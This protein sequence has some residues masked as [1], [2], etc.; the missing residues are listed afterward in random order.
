MPIYEYQCPD[1]GNEFEVMQ[2]IGAEAPACTR[3]GE[4]KVTKK[5]SRTS[6]VLKG[7]GWYKDGY[8]GASN[9][10][11]GSTSTAET[12]APAASTA[13]TSTP[14]PAAPAAPA[15]GSSSSGSS[16]SGSPST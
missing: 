4:P 15:S 9:Q 3:C 2:K 11:G 13:P 10:K 16:S 1:C 5:V 12:S 8:T 6:F 7:G 14:A